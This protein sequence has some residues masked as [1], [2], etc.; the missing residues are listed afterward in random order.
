MTVSLKDL[1]IAKR[2]LRDPCRS[3]PDHPAA[4]CPL[5]HE[6]ALRQQERQWRHKRE[7]AH[8]RYLERLARESV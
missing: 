7:A 2:S 1:R 8:V 4:T 3:H 5:C 6:W